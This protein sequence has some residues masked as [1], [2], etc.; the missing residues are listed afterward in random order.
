MAMQRAADDLAEYLGDVDDKGCRISCDRHDYWLFYFLYHRHGSKLLRDASGI[1]GGRYRRELFKEIMRLGLSSRAILEAREDLL[2]PESCF[3]WIENNERMF[4]W[5][6]CQVEKWRNKEF[7][8]EKSNPLNLS[9]RDSC[10]AVVDSLELSHDDKRHFLDSKRNDWLER[11]EVGKVFSWVGEYD[12]AKNA[13]LALSEILAFRP[14]YRGRSYREQPDKTL[15]GVLEALDSE[16]I[17]LHE[18]QLASKEAKAKLSQAKFRGKPGKKQLNV[19]IRADAVEALD[20][21][22]GE[23]GISK[24]KLVELLIVEEVAQKKYITPKR[25]A[26]MRGEVE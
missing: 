10:I 2:V 9:P 6:V 21:M 14:Q 19:H 23:A 1:G 7:D 12:E 20:R 5:F 3:K 8:A 26:W 18:A 17:T 11:L 13:E 24:A 25:A 16:K 22:A 15:G 4:R